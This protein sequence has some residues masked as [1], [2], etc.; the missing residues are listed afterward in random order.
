M[1]LKS[2]NSIFSKSNQRS[3]IKFL[4]ARC[5][6]IEARYVVRA[7]AG[8]MNPLPDETSALAALNFAVNQFQGSISKKPLEES[9]RMIKFAYNQVEL[10][11]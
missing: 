2:N 10:I 3:L 6:S 4:L 5:G 1:Q 11:N 9:L 7:L 8:K